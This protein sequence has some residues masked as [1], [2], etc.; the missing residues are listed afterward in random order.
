MAKKSFLCLVLSSLLCVCTP[1]SAEFKIDP[2]D[3][4][5]SLQKIM[6]EASRPSGQS[7]QQRPTLGTVILGDEDRVS[8]KPIIPRDTYTAGTTPLAFFQLKSPLGQEQTPGKQVLYSPGNRMEVIDMAYPSNETE[9]IMEAGGGRVPGVYTVQFYT[10]SGDLIGAGKFTV[11]PAQPQDKAVE[12][13]PSQSP[14]PPAQVARPQTQTVQPLSQPKTAQPQAQTAQPQ[15]QTAQPQTQTIARPPAQVARPQT[16]T[17]QPLSQ[18]KTAQPQT[19]TAQPQTRP[20]KQQIPTTASQTHTD[21]ASPQAPQAS[22]T[23]GAASG[24]PAGFIAVEQTRMTWSEAKNFCEQKGGRLP[25]VGGRESL[26]L[27]NYSPGILIESFGRDGPPDV[28]RCPAGLSSGDYWTGTDF[29]STNHPNSA[30]VVRCTGGIRT[31]SGGKGV[32]RWV[33]CVK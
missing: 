23:A 31:H 6:E 33:A 13:P 10:K 19:Q 15:T 24:L 29:P 27:A 14:S 16:Q 20:A 11:V 17:V 3:P 7:Y 32:G 30:W 5:K 26:A 28:D 1:A 2:Q 18:P 21:P 25:L 9:F 4:A 12:P 8:G 22:T